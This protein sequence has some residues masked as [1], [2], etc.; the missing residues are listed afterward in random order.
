[1][2]IRSFFFVVLS[3]F[4][5]TVQQVSTKRT[6]MTDVPGVLILPDGSKFKT[7]LYNMKVIGQ[8]RTTKKLPYFILAGTTCTE[9]DE[10]TS[11]YI[12]S[13]SDGPMKNEAEQRRFAYPGRETDY[14]TGKPTYEAEMFL[15]DCL[16]SHPNAVIWFERG[17]GEDNKWHSGVTVA[18]VR[19]DTLLVTQL[20]DRLPKLTEVQDAVRNGKCQELPGID[21][22]S[23]P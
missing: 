16:T 18:E 22:S 7:T 4:V 13:P 11:I 17:V 8:L 9:C 1:M 5:A 21:A 14:E 15:G 12:H 10:N 20:H 3:L 19:N 6:E 2:D 23:E